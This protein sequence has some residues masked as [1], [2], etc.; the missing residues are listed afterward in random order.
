M[1][2][3]SQNKYAPQEQDE[4]LPMDIGDLTDIFSFEFMR[5][6]PIWNFILA[7]L[8]CIGLPILIYHILKPY[9]GQVIAMV[10]ASAPPLLIVLW[11]MIR[12]KQF[13]VLGIVAGLAFLI[14]GI[15]SIA[16]PDEKVEAICEGIVPLLVGVFCVISIIP[17][18]IGSWELRP[19][20]FQ[21]ANQV[22][23]RS[24]ASQDLAA[25]DEQR[26][27]GHH[28]KTTSKREKLDWTYR[29]MAR[30]RQDMRIMT[31][32]W[33]LMLIVGFVIKLIVVLTDTDLG[34]AALAGYLIFGLGAFVVM[35][36]TGFYTKIC[37]GHLKQDIMFWQE[38]QHVSKP[39]DNSTEAAHNL[40]WGMQSVNNAWGQVMPV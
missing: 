24:D 27:N 30:F 20:V 25:Q 8:W 11:R 31:A 13:D 12:D 34:S 5:G 19:M 16:E 4:D 10:V 22:M 3:S 36:F 28:Q 37:K 21:L 1:N 2:N 38:K 18:K 23:P 39:I 33:G 40:N 9:L 32:V 17:I 26:L 14:S 35:I 15:V 7:I 6:R 29:H